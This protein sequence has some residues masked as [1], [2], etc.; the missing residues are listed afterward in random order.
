MNFFRSI[1]RRWF[2]SKRKND[3][4]NEKKLR[5]GCIHNLLTSS[6]Q[7]I[8]LSAAGIT[9]LAQPLFANTKTNITALDSKTSI[10]HD[11]T[12]KIHNISTTVKHGEKY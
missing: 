3:R 7:K 6:L 9:L 5:K 8:L 2:V 12:N 11:T 4:K 1:L 10:T